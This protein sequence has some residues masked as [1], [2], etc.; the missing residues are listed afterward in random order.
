MVAHF[1]RLTNLHVGLSTSTGLYFGSRTIKQTSTSHWDNARRTLQNR[2]IE[3]AVI[4]NDNASLLLEGLAYDQCQVGIVLN[5]DPLQLFPE[6]NI[7]EE[8]Q[9]FNVVRTQVDVVLPTGTSVLNADDSM[10]VKMAELSKG[11]VMYFSQDPA[12]SVLATHQENNGRS[13][14]VSPSIITL[15]QGKLD[16]LTIPIPPTIRD[17]SLDWAPNLS[18]AAAIGAAWALD[19]PFN[20]IE[21]GAE[22][23]VSDIS[24]PRGI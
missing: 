13:I 5:I 23:F 24:L 18:L 16:K 20:V 22:T 4:E 12:S 15:K 9:L 1:I 19:I 21:A 14:I 8:D 6:H 3:V 2:A 10:I 17:L 7:S 11:E